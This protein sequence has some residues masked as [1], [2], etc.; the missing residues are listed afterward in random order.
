M[1]PERNGLI[2]V[3][4]GFLLTV[5][6]S[7]IVGAYAYTY[8]NGE[9]IKGQIERRL[10]RIETKVDQLLHGFYGPRR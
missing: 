10:D 7:L 2:R 8:M 1:I 4:V 9:A 5:A 3:V 6:F